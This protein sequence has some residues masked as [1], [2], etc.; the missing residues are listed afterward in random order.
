M[1]EHARRDAGGVEDW[2]RE[3]SRWVGW[4]WFAGVMMI[5]IGVFDAIQGLVALVRREFYVVGP[6][7]LLVFDL[8]GW[9]WVHV[10]V[11]VL[12]ALTGIVLFSG[13]VWARAATVLLAALNAIAQL[14]FM[15]AY[16]MWSVIVIALCVVVIWAVIVHG[17][18]IRIAG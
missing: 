8:T 9:G 5:L 3:P 4:I 2:N 1:S 14:A 13:A 7:N 17:N 11:G 18:D 15:A 10:I 6:E 12:V 16:P